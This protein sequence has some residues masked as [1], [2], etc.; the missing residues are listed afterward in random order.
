MANRL[1]NLRIVD[2]VLSSLAIGYSNAGYIADVLF[3][4]ARVPKESGKIPKHNKQ[5]FKLFNTERALRA[6][7]NVVKPEDRSWIDF[8]LIEH[9]ISV[10]MDYR[11]ED[12]SDDLD[13]Q[14]SNAIIAQEG[15]QLRREKVCA[16]LAFNPANYAATNKETLATADKFTTAGSDPFP[17]VARAHEQIRKSIA[18]RANTMVLGATAFSGLRYHPKVLEKLSY[19]QLGIVTPQILAA[20]FDVERV[21]IGD[22]I[23]VSD[24]NQTTTDVWGGSM[25]LTYVRPP[26]PNVKRS[27][28][29]PNYGYTVY[30]KSAEVDTYVGEGGKVK[31]V[32]NTMIYAPV[33]VGADAGYLVSGVV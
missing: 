10:P 5:A 26:Q 7:S 23:W 17:I 31:Y 2:P 4:M 3:P 13:L 33:L 9:D 18:R 8:S 24:D 6:A 22:A 32:R 16:D 21:V 15:I 12:E 29:E 25:L 28:Y 27:V 30:K 11:E 14:A 20:L 1:Q 19:A